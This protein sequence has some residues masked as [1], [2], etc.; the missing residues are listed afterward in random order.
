VTGIDQWVW[1]AYAIIDVYVESE[2]TVDIYDQLTRRS[3][4]FSR[5]RRPDPLATGR[6]LADE[7]IWTPREY[8]L[9][10]IEIRMIQILREW[11]Y[12][13]DQVER[14]IKR[15]VCGVNSTCF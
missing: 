7:P 13:V 1:S 6:I 3:R 11:N 12:I 2:E 5:R 8:F 9:K 10:V 4:R 14:D 15:Y